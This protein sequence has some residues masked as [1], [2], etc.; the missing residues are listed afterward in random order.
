MSHQEN[1]KRGVE[2]ITACPKGHPYTEENTAVYGG[3]RVCRSCA[4]GY[5]VDRFGH[6]FVADPTYTG[7]HRRCVVCHARKYPKPYLCIR[8]HDLRVYAND[9]GRCRACKAEIAAK[10]NAGK[11]RRRPSA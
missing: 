10:Y 11:R 1:L 2:T 6:E 4:V 3:G 7:K 9:K 8:G 5:H